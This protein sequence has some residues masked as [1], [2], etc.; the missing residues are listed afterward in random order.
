MA[1]ILLADDDPVVRL[2][3]R[4]ALQGHKIVLATDGRAAL[5]E[6][7]AAI[8]EKEPFDLVITDHT[9]PRMTGEELCHAIQG[10]ATGTPIILFSSREFE[11]ERVRKMGA[12]AF[13]HKAK[14]FGELVRRA[15]SLLR[16][17][18]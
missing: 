5:V 17:Q 10:L 2:E 8:H 1:K 18:I 11:P 9:M 3:A 4:R 14:G 15:D 13:V 7:N 6:F 12:A 16:P